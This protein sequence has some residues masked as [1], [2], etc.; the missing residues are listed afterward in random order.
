V[1][2]YRAQVALVACPGSRSARCAHEQK[3]G[4]SIDLR[5]PGSVVVRRQG[6]WQ[7]PQDLVLSEEWNRTQERI[8]VV[9]LER[10]NLSEFG[11]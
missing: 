5:A 10:E 9:Q 8:V 7:I 6:K 2:L 4:Y 11:P 1:V 3:T